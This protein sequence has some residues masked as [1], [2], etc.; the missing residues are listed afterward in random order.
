MGG[1][2]QGMAGADR[3]RQR[4][5]DYVLGSPPFEP[6][7]G[8]EVGPP[9]YLSCVGETESL[10]GVSSEEW[11]YFISPLDSRSLGAAVRPL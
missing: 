7:L 2:G 4:A 9:G 3:A 8:A 5:G 1:E 11:T 10:T 6:L